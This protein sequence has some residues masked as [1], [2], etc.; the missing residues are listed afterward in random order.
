MV[1]EKKV[2]LSSSEEV[3]ERLRKHK[4]YQDTVPSF[5]S[6]RRNNVGEG[7]SSKNELTKPPYDTHQ[8]QKSVYSKR[9]TPCC[10]N[11]GKYH[12]EECWRLAGRCYH[13]G[14]EGHR[15]RDCPLRSNTSKRESGHGQ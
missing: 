6:K 12:F 5:P 7:K 3:S 13:C 2:L 14:D 15:N 8:D 11:C 1:N 9:Q 4:E 10:S